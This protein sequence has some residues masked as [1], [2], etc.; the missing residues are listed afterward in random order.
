M[1]E[2]G[3]SAYTNRTTIDINEGVIANASRKYLDQRAAAS[4]VL[5]PQPFGIQAEYSIGKGPQFNRITNTVEETFLEGGYAT[6]SYITN[7][8]GQEL[9]PFAR[10]EYYDGGDKADRD[11][12]SYKLNNWE[13]GLE[14]SPVNDIEFTASYSIKS[15]TT[16]DF[17]KPY[18]FQEGN[19]LTLQFQAN[20]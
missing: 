8:K 11:A 14:W 6:L 3:V 5:Y 12:R 15:E 9:V 10:Y 19:G 7:V 20:F 13:L 18:N 2:A 17:N 16:G 4:F 1:I